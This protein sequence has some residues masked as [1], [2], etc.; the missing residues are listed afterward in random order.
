M[1]PTLVTLEE[2]AECETVAH[3]LALRI[4]QIPPPEPGDPPIRRRGSWQRP[5]GR[6]TSSWRG[7]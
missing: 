1:W 2:L 3:V 6:R 5:E 7:S 4:E